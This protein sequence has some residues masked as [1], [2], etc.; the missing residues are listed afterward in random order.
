MKTTTRLTLLISIAILGAIV[1]SP[2]PTYAA[3]L[4]QLT[5][6][7]P[8][9]GLSPATVEADWANFG[10]EI[11]ITV[12][13][14]DSNTS[15]ASVE[16]VTAVVSSEETEEEL[17]IFLDE[18]GA[19]TGVFTG[20]FVVSDAATTASTQGSPI[21]ATAS[22][23]PEIEADDED[24]LDIVFGPSITSVGIENDAPD[25]D[26]LYPGQD[27]VVPDRNVDFTVEITD[28]DS[29]IPDPDSDDEGYIAVFFLV[30]NVQCQD[31]DLFS[32]GT[33]R[34]LVGS[35]TVNSPA[36]GSILDADCDGNGSPDLQLVPPDDNDFQSINNGFIVEKTIRLSL[37][38]NFVAV[39]AYD[40]A[41]NLAVSTE[42]D[43]ASTRPSSST[44]TPTLTPSPT[45]TPTPTVTA[46]AT[47]MPMPTPSATP[48]TATAPIE[49]PS[50]GG[51]TPS[52]STSALIAL[53]GLASI[54]TGVWVLRKRN[55]FR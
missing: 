51:Y 38:T 3:P 44:R 32:G 13:D 12:T 16:S 33:P 55:L 23:R 47:P 9:T 18:T 22:P 27:A 19:S 39:A 43:S 53:A 29:G 20:S 31:S 30:S 52:P 37:G 54:I 14:S 4:I 28:E 15:N 48:A 17:F 11:T 6:P 10:T 49:P 50:V 2:R 25:I 1:F 36:S 42:Q 21:S 26:N 45:P 35:G 46:T 34:P 5:K 7:N 40:N 8:V 41:G 24:E